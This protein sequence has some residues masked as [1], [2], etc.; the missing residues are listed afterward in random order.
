[1]SGQRAETMDPYT[2]EAPSIRR[3]MENT[4]EKRTSVHA[5]AGPGAAATAMAA[6][7]RPAVASTDSRI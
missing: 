1:M 6:K 3:E 5:G 2:M 7:E 4:L